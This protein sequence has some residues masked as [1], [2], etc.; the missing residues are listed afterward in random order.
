MRQ[1]EVD[2]QKH[3]GFLSTWKV[4]GPFDNKDMKG[5]AVVYPPESNLDLSAEF[6]GQLD[7]V[8]WKP[9]VHDDDYGVVDI[10]EQFDNYKGSLMYATTTYNSENDQ[11]VEFG[12]ARPMPG[13]CGS[14][15]NWSLNGRS[16][17]AALAWTST[18]SR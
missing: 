5:F 16:I 10:A 18:R 17:I 15:G 13:S 9:V 7:R 3:F 8:S 14:M 1:V 6:D 11:S 12:S 2:L 4:I